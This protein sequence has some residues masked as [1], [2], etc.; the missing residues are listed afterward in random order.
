MVLI[1]GE[2]IKYGQTTCMC[3]L[4]SGIPYAWVQ[5]RFRSH[6]IYKFQLLFSQ[7][8]GSINTLLKQVRIWRPAL[9]HVS[10]PKVPLLL[11]YPCCIHSKSKNVTKWH[12][13]HGCT[14]NIKHFP[15]FI[16]LMLKK[17]TRIDCSNVLPMP[18]V[19]PGPAAWAPAV[20]AKARSFWSC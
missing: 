5:T 17:W 2:I 15:L 20:L 19:E 1:K 3:V 12:M 10:C 6:E 4:S 8:V 9:R 13:F 14:A 16:H 18:G 7:K 11:L